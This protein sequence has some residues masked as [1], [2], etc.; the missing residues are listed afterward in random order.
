MNTRSIKHFLLAG[1]VSCG[2]ATGLTACSDW[3]DHYDGIANSGT[4]GA[5]IW[6]Q[7]KDN[8]QLSDVC[9]VLEQTKV[10]RMHK[11]TPVSYAELLRGGQ[12]FTAIAPLNG[13]FNKD[14]LLQLVQTAAGDS[15]V[16]R[17]F[18]QNHLSRSLVSSMANTT[19]VLML[20]MKHLYMGN[21]KIDNV[22]ITIANQQA[23]NG[24]F[25]VIDHALNYKRNLYE[26]F[27]DNPSLTVIGDKLR[28][29]NEDYFDDNAS[30]SN[31]VIDGVPVYVDSVVYELNPMLSSLGELESEDSTYLVVAPTTEGWNQAYQEVSEYFK[32]DQTVDNRD[33][34]QQY[35]T[36]HALLE[37]AIFNMTDQKSVNDSLISVPFISANQ[38]YGKGKQIYHVFKKPF[39]PGGI[40]DGAEALE[41]SNGTLYTTPQWSFKPEE[42]FFKE[43]YV[44]G[45]HSHLI[46]GYDE[47]LCVYN[48]RQEPN[49][50]ISNGGYL[51]INATES[52]ANWNIWY[53]V[54]NTLSGSYDVY[55]VI[56]PKRI[57]DADAP[58]ANLPCKF[59][60]FIEYNDENGNSKSYSCKINNK[61]EF[62]TDPERID[63]ILIASDFKF[64]ACNYG[65]SN[66]NVKIRLQCYV[67]KKQTDDYS[68]EIYLDCFYLRP[69]TSKSE[70]Q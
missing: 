28:F 50:S 47:D 69:R 29:Y 17:S 55:A 58:E 67:T 30:V 34:L 18:I 43:I 23:H 25:H 4:S 48:V 14:S 42:T 65:L 9:E 10:Y 70:E 41:C 12:A 52:T 13:T 57:Y 46:V 62:E 37:D 38:L 33:S 6:Q 66:S 60:A 44:E 63:T 45:E 64:P 2:I 56:L 24:V 54:A 36:V 59:K 22:P 51:R 27:C 39:E 53:K 11:K 8:P 3:D 15:S 35:Y 40:L 31:G 61:T 32:F 16:E 26:M 49:D 19:K 68:R 20:N 21:N 1:V 7:L 5:T